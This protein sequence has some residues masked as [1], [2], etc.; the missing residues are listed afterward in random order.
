VAKRQPKGPSP[1]A[2]PT[3][4]WRNL[5][6]L[7]VAQVL[8]MSVWFSASA[9]TPQLTEAWALTKAQ[10][11][12]MTMSVQIGFVIGALVSAILNLPDRFSS[13]LII[14]ASA[15]IAATA[16]AYIPL[17]ADGPT[18]A[19]IARFVTGAALAGVYPPGM[20][21]V[22]SWTKSDRG[23]G[24]GLLVGAITLGSAAPHFLNALPMATALNTSHWPLVLGATS[25]QCA[26]GGAVVLFGV[27]EG[28]FLAATAPFNWKHIG[29]VLSNRP[30]RLANFGYF[31]HMWELYAMWVWAPTLL[32]A[33]YKAAGWPATWARV[34]GFA[35]IAVGAIG[36]VYAGAI[37]DRRGRV[38]VTSASLAISGSCCLIAGLL[39]ESPLVL[40]LLCLV[41]GVAVVSASAQF[42]SAISE[43]SDRHYV[44]TALTLQTSIG[45]ALTL[46]SIRIIPSIVELVGWRWAL[47]VLAI[48]PLFG[49]WSMQALG[50]LPEA[51]KMASGNR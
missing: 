47:C 36:C 37:A 9:V 23:L 48:G 50:D 31:G 8:A 43:L 3:G 33:S 45:F 21:I 11:A 26:I 30:T 18:S 14:G 29:S 5:S 41:W 6:L 16:N 7:A 12:W 34:G 2:F 42:S 17:F 51:S 1:L 10:T 32:A 24:I 13:K 39:F 28:P 15:V 4:K 25:V 38:A 40:T 20:K 49:I 44:G 27:R 19:L 46:I 35:I 22:A